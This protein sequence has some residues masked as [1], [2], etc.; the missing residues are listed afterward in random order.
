MH[1][2]LLGPGLLSVNGNTHRRQR[3]LLNPPFSHA[4]MRRIAPLMTGISLQLRDLII[5]EV[6]EISGERARE[7]D[8]GEWLGRAA[9][10]VLP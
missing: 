8:L 6:A 9:L 7:V 10:C 5:N 3:K 2:Y 1:L 4:H